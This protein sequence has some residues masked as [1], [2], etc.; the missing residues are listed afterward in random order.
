MSFVNIHPGPDTELGFAD[1][2]CEVTGTDRSTCEDVELFHLQNTVR[3]PLT[4]TAWPGAGA[5]LMGHW[6]DG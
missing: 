1:A 5:A 4:G 2:S 6:V 3:S